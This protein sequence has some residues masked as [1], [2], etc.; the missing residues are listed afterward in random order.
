VCDVRLAHSPGRLDPR[1]L[2]SLRGFDVAFVID[3]GRGERAL[4]SVDTKYHERNKVEQPKPKN[5]A[6]NMEV[7]DRS[8]VFAPTARGLLEPSDLAVMWLEH[9][10]LLSMLQH[11]SRE[12]TWGRHVVVHPADNTDVADAAAR[13]RDFLTDDAGFAT[14]TIEALLDSG[15]LRR[16]TAAALRT[17]YLAP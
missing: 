10:L 2:N 14:M 4:I 6:R 3:V 17:R 16:R 13:Y 9:L 8:G 7:C 1:Y 11:E 5:A 15:A 12:W